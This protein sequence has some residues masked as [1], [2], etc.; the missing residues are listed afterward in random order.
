MTVRRFFPRIFLGLSTG[1]LGRLALLTIL[2]AGL[3][4]GCAGP[5]GS[6][7]RQ[8]FQT[9]R[10]GLGPTFTSALDAYFAELEGLEKTAAREGGASPWADAGAKAALGEIASAIAEIRAGR[11]ADGARLLEAAAGRKIPPEKAAEALFAAADAWDRAGDAERARKARIRI[12]SLVDETLKRVSETDARNR[13]GEGILGIVTRRGGLHADERTVRT[14]LER[15][16]D[17]K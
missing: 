12:K 14:D 13:F 2:L 15:T 7:P 11:H 3:S 16:Y 17:R 8:G 6:K 4:T 5:C 9:V 1:R 10:T